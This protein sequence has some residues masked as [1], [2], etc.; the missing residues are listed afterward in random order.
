MEFYGSLLTSILATQILILYLLFRITFSRSLLALCLI[1]S[2]L[3]HNKPSSTTLHYSRGYGTFVGSRMSE[4]QT[5]RLPSSRNFSRG[6]AA[7]LT[8]AGD[9]VLNSQTIRGYHCKWRRCEKNRSI[10]P[11]LR[12][13]TSFPRGSQ[14]RLF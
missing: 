14:S 8:W 9:L 13:L 7:T 2:Y 5:R 4:G 10:A 11:W 1:S 3:F 12:A 6:S